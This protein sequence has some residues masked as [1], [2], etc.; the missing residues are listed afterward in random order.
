MLPYMAAPWI[1]WVIISNR[2][3]C[4]CNYSHHDHSHWTPL[5]VRETLP[6]LLFHNEETCLIG[7]HYRQVSQVCF[8]QPSNHV[9][10]FYTFPILS[11][12]YL[13][14]LVVSPLKSSA[15]PSPVPTL[16]S[17]VRAR[18]SASASQVRRFTVCSSR[19]WSTQENGPIF[20][21]FWMGCWWFF[22]GCLLDL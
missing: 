21:G 10:S 9:C 22:V 18:P 11:Y 7:H 4:D 15:V 6:D 8:S 3:H 14:L 1:L 5:L 2:C 20:D 12:V 13:Y 16:G 19:S 17:S